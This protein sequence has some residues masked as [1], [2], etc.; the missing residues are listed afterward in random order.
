M[1]AS[2]MY[3]WRMP[4]STRPQRTLIFFALLF[5]GLPALCQESFRNRGPA[6]LLDIS[7]A[8]QV[9]AGD[10]AD[11]FGHS[12]SL[13]LGLDHITAESNW[14]IGLSGN[15]TFG[16]SV[17]E[18]VLSNLR[19]PEGYIYGNNQG[20]AD[21]GLGQR[22]WFL[23]LRGGKLVSLGAKNPRSGL[24][25]TLGAG[26]W[27]H[28]VRI[29]ED[30]SSVVPQVTGSYLKGYDRLSSG[31]ALQQFAGYQHMSKDGRINFY[32]GVELTEGFTRERR[33]I[34]Y[35]TGNDL[36]GSRLD[37]N[38]GFRLGWILPFFMGGGEEIFY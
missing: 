26:F 2:N 34:G 38:I 3:L 17:K 13:G 37:L 24:R 31:M 8:Y 22:G 5:A 19:S 28:R 23:G 1:K 16:N 30:P 15:F 7:Y 11:R 21:I 32:F 25:L 33:G 18:D 14:L 6:L 36:S 20:V 27:E 12:F 10:L 4:R 9:P 29:R 35:N